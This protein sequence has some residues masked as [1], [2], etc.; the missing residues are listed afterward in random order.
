MSRVVD[1]RHQAEKQV[2]SGEQDQTPQCRFQRCLRYREF[3][4]E[5]YGDQ[6]TS[7]AKDRARRSRSNALRMPPQADQATSDPAGGVNQQVGSAIED[8]LR[9]PT[10]IPQAPHV[11]E[12]VDDSDVN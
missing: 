1:P 7:Q 5:Q 4:Q 9:Q 10:E 11:E 3:T 8:A 6:P 2:V 12:N